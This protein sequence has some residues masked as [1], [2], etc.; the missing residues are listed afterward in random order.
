MRESRTSD[1]EM[2]YILKMLCRR[3]GLQDL[4]YIKLQG[5]VAQID[6]DGFIQFSN[7]R[8]VKTPGN[9]TEIP[10]VL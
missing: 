4:L 7:C 8:P 2:L 10:Q 6:G 1:T 9:A 3:L 5:R